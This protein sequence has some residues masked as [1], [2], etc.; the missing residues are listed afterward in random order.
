MGGYGGVQMP[1]F[2]KLGAL[3]L[4]GS[5]DLKLQKCNFHLS[6]NKEPCEH[7][8]GLCVTTAPSVV[9]GEVVVVP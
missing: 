2:G 9:S 4:T 3:T 5:G 1:L 7:V 8:L 6:Q